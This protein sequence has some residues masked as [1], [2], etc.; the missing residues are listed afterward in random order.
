MEET[1]NSV[2][3]V[4]CTT[5]SPRGAEKPGFDY[6]F[7]PSEKF[8]E[9]LQNDAFAE[10]AEVHGHFYGT[11]RATVDEALTHGRLAVFDIDVQGGD[12]LRERYPSTVTVFVIPP[13]YEELARRLRLRQTDPEE[14]IRS[15]SSPPKA[16]FVAAGG[17]TTR[18][19]MTFSNGRLTISRLSSARSDSAAEGTTP[20][21]WGCS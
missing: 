10:W 12:Q 5:R 13:S 15:G 14:Q 9:M 18:C 1:P 11:P 8:R 17:T 16:R 20:P 4:S 2:F 6:Q 3:S 21:S 7:L 19:S